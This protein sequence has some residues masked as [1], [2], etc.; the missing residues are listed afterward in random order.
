MTPSAHLAHGELVLA[1]DYHPGWVAAIKRLRRRRWDPAG[2]RWHVPAD[3]APELLEALTQAEAPADWLD[4]LAPHAREAVAIAA[5]RGARAQRIYETAVPTLKD[6]WPT[7]FAHQREGVEFLLTPRPW[8]GAILAD[9]MG[10]GKTRQAIAAAHEAAPDG[11]HLIACPAGLTRHWAREIQKALPGAAVAVAGKGLAIAPWTVISYDRLHAHRAALTAVAWECLIL[12]EAHYVKNP[13][14]RRTRMVLGEAGAPGL[15][16]RAERVWLLTGTPVANRPL[17]LFALLRALRHPLGDDQLAFGLKYCN[18]HQTVH[19]WDMRGASNLDDLRARLEDIL[20][21]RTKEE[22]LDLPPKLRT[23][24]PVEVDLTAYRRVWL[25]HAERMHALARAK[26]RYPRRTLLAEIAKL[27]HAAALAKIPAALALAEEMLEAGEKAVVFTLHRAVVK[28]F[29]ERFA[30]RL[31]TVVGGQT[32]RTRQAQVDAFETDPGIGLLVGDLRAAGHG[33]T[34]AAASQ[35]IFVDY[36]WTPAEHLQA[37]DRAHRIGQARSVTVTYLSAV[38]TI[39]EDVEQLLA[40]KLEVA[41]RLIDGTAPSQRTSFLDDLL[42]VVSRAP[43][44][45]RPPAAQ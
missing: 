44:G 6:R 40:E 29:K 24:M 22:V 38:G 45:S 37:E 28:A 41:G 34:L 33:F 21:R 14:A 23:Y 20:L 9:E 13:R 10:L 39:D 2:K 15:A 11:P 43:R 31:A 25:A 12:D 18:A 19:G 8:R 42:A 1:F 4:Q 5:A 30:G 32:S 7:L 16:D 17:D 27:R 26:R 3:L 36:A 35:V